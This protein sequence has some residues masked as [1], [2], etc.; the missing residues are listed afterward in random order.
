MKTREPFAY[1][2]T[3]QRALQP[4][5]DSGLNQLCVEECWQLARDEKGADVADFFAFYT[6]LARLGDGSPQDPY[7]WVPTDL[8][9]VSRRAVK[10]VLAEVAPMHPEQDLISRLHTRPAEPGIDSRPSVS[11]PRPTSPPPSSVSKDVRHVH[12][13]DETYIRGM[14][15][16]SWPFV[17]GQDFEGRWS[18]LGCAVMLART[19]WARFERKDRP[20]VGRNADDWAKFLWDK[21]GPGGPD[22]ETVEAAATTMGAHAATPFAVLCRHQRMVDAVWNHSSGRLL[23]TMPRFTVYPQDLAYAEKVTSAK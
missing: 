8:T 3:S 18:G 10:K 21:F 17:P 20:Q 1:D 13:G 2:L 4:P 23:L 6:F 12:A 5:G 11:P 7:T 16:K 22:E 14:L 9:Y 15:R 19:A